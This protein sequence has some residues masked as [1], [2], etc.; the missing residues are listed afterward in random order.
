MSNGLS[1]SRLVRETIVFFSKKF[2]MGQRG[3]LRGGGGGGNFFF[4]DGAKGGKGVR[5]RIY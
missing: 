2:Q 4:L 3:A 1:F 5:G